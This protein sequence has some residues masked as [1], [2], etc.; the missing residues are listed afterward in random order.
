MAVFTQVS[1]TDLHAFLGKYSP[2][3]GDF[4]KLE[5]IS[6]GIEN[7]NYFLHTTNAVYVLTIFERLALEQLP[8]YLD[9]MANLASNG[10]CVPNPI[11]D[12]K[13]NILNILCGKPATI[14]TKLAGSS[15][16]EPNQSNLSELGL[17]V[18][19]MHM[20]SKVSSN[21]NNIN[22]N[23]LSLNQPNLR[24]LDWWNETIPTIL[25]FVTPDIKQKLES[26]LEFQN[27]FYN[28]EIYKKLPQGACHCD[29]FCDNALFNENKLSGIF[30]FYFAGFDTFLF[31][32]CVI[33]N[34]WCIYRDRS[35]PSFGKINLDLYNS[36]MQSYQS[37]RAFTPAETDAI[38]SML[39]AAALRF[40]VSRLWDWYLPRDSQ[41]LK[42]H[43][44]T[45]FELI[46][47]KRVNNN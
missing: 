3:I 39:R 34:D 29:L 21:K 19:K 6:G 46:L 9:L 45:H 42:P 4:I 27:I 47:S 28:S 11:K 43:D 41:L 14:V 40:W 10:I 1:D 7:T 24:G 30:D 25:P 2:D 37:I 8:F 32:I 5:G 22:I 33:I 35:N 20:V 12:N 36:F 38:P 23:T 18:A 31:D 26:E 17:E 15:I 16:L 44:P 13:G